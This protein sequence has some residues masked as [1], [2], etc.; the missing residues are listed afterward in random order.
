MKEN[1]FQRLIMRSVVF[2]AIFS[3]LMISFLD[4]RTVYA[5]QGSENNLQ[6]FSSQLTR[7]QRL[8]YE[9]FD[10]QDTLPI[11]VQIDTSF[12][13]GLELLDSKSAETQQ[14]AIKSTQEALLFSLK[15]YKLDLVHS[16][17]FIPFMA[18][19]VDRTAF[20]ALTQ[21]K[22]VTNIE[23]DIVVKATL[24]ESVPLIQAPLVWDMGYTGTGQAVA[25]LDTGVDKTYPMLSGKIVSEACYST[26]GDDTYSLCPGGVSE[27]T[28]NN[29]AMPYLGICPIGKC[30]H[31]THV[32]GIAAGTIGV[33]K[34]SKIIAIQV[35]HLDI[36]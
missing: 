36:W 19:H 30:D 13:P 34:N 16:F 11:I 33:A 2:V 3:L 26:N 27:L 24:T 6:I 31:G 14:A 17:Q 1:R 35:F 20:E 22:L 7:Q 23:E 32:S 10:E 4:R 29:S 21:S 12:R 28:A 15:E 5:K 18:M 9:K 8:L 25:I